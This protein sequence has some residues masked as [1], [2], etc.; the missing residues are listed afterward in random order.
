MG[1]EQ[2]VQP[3]NPLWCYKNEE[4]KEHNIMIPAMAQIQTTRSGVKLVNHIYKATVP[5]TILIYKSL[6]INPSQ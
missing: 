2:K 4:V 6:P 1:T 3:H 5:P